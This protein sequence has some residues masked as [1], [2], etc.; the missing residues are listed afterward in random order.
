MSTQVDPSARCEPDA[1]GTDSRVGPYSLIEDGA[2]LGE[3]VSVGSHVVIR[4]GA[5]IGDSVV[6]EDGVIVGRNAIVASGV[7][8]GDGATVAPGTE[9]GEAAVVE[10]GAVVARAVPRQAVV[11]GN[12]A[13]ITGYVGA[14]GP[15]PLQ[16]T[17]PPAAIADSEPGPIVADTDVQGVKLYRLPQARDLRG[18]LVAMEL[19]RLLPF[20]ARRYF[21]VFD[22]PG[23]EVRGEHAHRSCQQFLVAVQ[24]QLNVIADDGQHRQEFV[25]DDRATGLYLPPL[26]WAVQYK[27]SRD[28]VLLVLASDP[29]HEAD[30]IRDYSGFIAELERR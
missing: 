25:L 6:V 20:V 22:V 18:S 19:E 1:I 8:L 10:T 7:R 23:A 2:Q 5:R 14:D 15:S 12:P 27:Y 3:R 29:Y 17:R 30:Y 24:G 4:T 11:S 9:I 13:R 16:P 28:C 21:L 26:V